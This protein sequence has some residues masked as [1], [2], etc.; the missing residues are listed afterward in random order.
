MKKPLNDCDL[1]KNQYPLPVLIEN[2]DYL[3]ASALVRWQHLDS[4]FCKKYILNEDNQS[5]EERYKIDPQYV[6]KYQPH[7]SYYE[8][9]TSEN[10][11]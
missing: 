3:S 9:I 11:R 4:D 2:V 5:V 8:L 10:N 6:L 7:L 1:R